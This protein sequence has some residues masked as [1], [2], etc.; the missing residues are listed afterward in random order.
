MEVK[1][2]Y[3]FVFTIIVTGIILGVAVITF[4]NFGH[5]V[6]DSTVLLNE[7]VTMTA[8]AGT[9][10]NDDVTAIAGVSNLTGEVFQNTNM[11]NG[12]INFTLGG[13]IEVATE[14]NEAVLL[15]NY[16][17]LRDTA[18]TDMVD[19]MET[20]ITPIAT[21]WIPLIVTIAALAIVLLLVIRSF[22]AHGRK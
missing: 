10:A 21:T 14:L 3:P 12:S 11:D 1:N 17:Y 2:L 7:S 19:N 5:A 4:Y 20:A 9:T 13:N 16:T 18:G 8:G 15:V 6:K 22:G